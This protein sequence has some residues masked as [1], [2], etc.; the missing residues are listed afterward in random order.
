MDIPFSLAPPPQG[1][2]LLLALGRK[3]HD[4]FGHIP[5]LHFVPADVYWKMP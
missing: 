2:F 1:F 5:Y 4:K 3:Q